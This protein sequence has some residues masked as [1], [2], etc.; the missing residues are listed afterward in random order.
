MASKYSDEDFFDED[1]NLVN[2]SWQLDQQQAEAVEEK[3]RAQEEKMSVMRETNRRLAVDN[4]LADF[5]KSVSESQHRRH[6]REQWMALPTW[7]KKMPRTPLT[8]PPT[9]G[10]K[11]KIKYSMTGKVSLTE[12]E[13]GRRI[14]NLKR[15]Q[16]AI[17]DY[18]TIHRPFPEGASM[19]PVAVVPLFPGV[20]STMIS[21]GISRAFAENRLD[22][23]ISAVVDLGGGDNR[24]PAWYEKVGRKAVMMKSILRLI[25]DYTGPLPHMNETFQR[26]GEGEYLLENHP[27]PERR[28]DPGIEDVVDI[29]RY[30][31][32]TK[33]VGIFDCDS[34]DKDSMLASVALAKTRIF[35]LPIAADAHKKLAALFEEIRESVGEDRYQKIVDNSVLVISGLTPSTGTEK[36]KRILSQ[37]LSKSA[38][39]VGIDP[40]R[41]ILIP[42]DKAL[43]DPPLAWDSLKFSTAHTFR[44]LAGRIVSDVVGEPNRKTLLSQSIGG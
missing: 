18:E 19:V 20:G 37:I 23:G 16:V 31:R 7:I 29:Y 13:R 3:K 38:D 32:P 36:G 30:M 2:T 25:R 9:E 21:R 34:Q 10:R 11:E 4:R 43:D 22:Y 1:G 15:V 26:G 33:G 8:A 5:E 28:I 40:D 44:W 42:H 27:A 35:V 39:T 6:I 41:T 14:R 17:K 12:A 24:L